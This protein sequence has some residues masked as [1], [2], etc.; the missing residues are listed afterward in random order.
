[1]YN[2]SIK[3]RFIET[4]PNEEQKTMYKSLFNRAQGF[5]T[6]IGK[7]LYAFGMQ[8]CWDFINEIGSKSIVHIYA[9]KSQYGRYAEWCI[10]NKIANDNYWILVYG[11][12]SFVRRSFALRYVKDIDT[13]EKIVETSLTDIYDKYLVYLLYMGLKGDNWNELRTLKSSDVDIK[14]KTIKTQQNEYPIIAPLRRAIQNG[15][16]V[17]EGKHRDVHSAYFIK[18]FKT[19]HLEGYPISTNNINSTMSKLNNNYYEAKKE[20]R[21]YTALTI[22]WSGLY[23]AMYMKER[24]NNELTLEDIYSVWGAYGK[25]EEAIKSRGYPMKQ[26][27]LYKEIFWGQ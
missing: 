5:E 4:L 22:H 3:K 24:R 13:L 10:E 19:K 11:D 20:K 1:M 6:Q 14:N 26:Y 23:Y 7:D 8:N 21:S 2:E 9:L 18:P 27:E 17:M 15:E 25:T 12:E 16:Y